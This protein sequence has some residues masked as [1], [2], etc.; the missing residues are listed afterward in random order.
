MD[1]RYQAYRQVELNTTNR[2]KIVVMLY[3]GAITFLNKTKMYMEKKD[4]ENKSKYFTKALNILDELNVSLDMQKG[5]EI[6]K[7]LKSL[8]LFLDRFLNQANFE[9]S[10]EKIDRAIQILESLH[11]AFEEVIKNPEFQEAQSI[12]KMEQAQNCIRKIV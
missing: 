5:G 8:Y 3:S 4:Y 6:A 10:T 1:N 12:S 11:S 2:G 7:N 9:N